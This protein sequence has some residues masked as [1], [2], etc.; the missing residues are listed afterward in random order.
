MNKNETKVVV[1]G[2][3]NVDI[4]VRL[5]DRNQ[6]IITDHKY[7]PPELHGGGTAANV[8]VSLARLGVPVSFMGSV[9]AD[10]YG[11]WV[12]EDFKREGIEISGLQMVED[13]FTVMV[14]ALIEPNGERIIYVWP[15]TGGAHNHFT[16]NEIDLS[17]WPSAKW[18]HTTGIC[19][20]GKPVRETVLAAMVEARKLGW[21]VSLDLNLRTESWGLNPETQEI[22]ERAIGLSDVVFGNAEEEILPLSKKR[23]LESAVKGLCEN[24]RVIIARQGSEG[25]LICTPDGLFHSPALQVKVVDTL[26]AGDAFNAG[27]IAAQ[28]TGADVA[29]ASKRGNETAALKI[30]YSGARGLPKR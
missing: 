29:E 18:L 5:P 28:I 12:E 22:F 10:N 23:S 15:P 9:G 25:A 6:P 3:S 26:G 19:L 14:M 11:H 7:A 24:K 17:S 27:F 21:E 4:L 30:Q 20:R 8:A 13:A 16:L 2:D 1:L